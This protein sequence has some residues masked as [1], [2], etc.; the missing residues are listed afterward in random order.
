DL[1]ERLSG[2]DAT[3]NLLLEMQPIMSLRA[4]HESMNFEVLLRMREA[5]GRVVPA[6]AVIA[7]AEKSGR[8]SMIDRWVLTTT[9]AWI[10]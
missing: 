9:L 5:D 8:A 3:D 6:G 10:A 1:V 2:P 7:A 4:P